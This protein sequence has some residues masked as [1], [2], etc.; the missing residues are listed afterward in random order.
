M[1]RKVRDRVTAATLT[2]TKLSSAALHLLQLAVEFEAAKTGP[3]AIG[4]ELEHAAEVQRRA[5]PVVKTANRLAEV[6]DL[7]EL[8]RDER[9]KWR[10]DALGALLLSWTCRFLQRFDPRRLPVERRTRIAHILQLKFMVYGIHLTDG[11]ADRLISSV[12]ITAESSRAG[13]NEGTRRRIRSALHGILEGHG[14]DYLRDV[15]DA[16]TKGEAHGGRIRT[17]QDA[18]A[19]MGADEGRRSL[20][21]ETLAYVLRLIVAGVRE[22][23]GEKLADGLVNMLVYIWDCEYADLYGLESK[24]NWV[25]EIRKRFPSTPTPSR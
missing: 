20:K 16:I 9:V 8:D 5:W 3:H 25:G 18:F 14:E 15:Q 17:R 13:T 23:L 4:S 1:P 6:V 24:G 7:L 11:D 10:K 19:V 21:S 22:D 12:H 2:P